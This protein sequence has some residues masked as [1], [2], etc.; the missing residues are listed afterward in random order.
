MTDDKEPGPVTDPALDEILEE[1]KS[2]EPIFHRPER[3][4]TRADF[5]KMMVLDFWET[6]ASGQRYSREYVLSVLA[7][8]YSKE[9]TDQW[10]T[11]EFLCRKLAD[12]V[13]LLTYTLFQGLRKTR[14]ATIWQ[15]SPQGWQ[16]VYHQGTIVQDSETH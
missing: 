7:E 1:L 11:Q 12:G 13:Y 5:E 9:Y 14:R 2:R 4:I 6:G 16:I 10:K 3:G 15:R 8:R